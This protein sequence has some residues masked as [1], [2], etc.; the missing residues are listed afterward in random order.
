MTGRDSNRGACAQSCR[1]KYSLVEEKRPNEY[2]PNRRRS[3]WNLYNEFKGFMY[4]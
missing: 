2:F 3:A 1:W 4:D